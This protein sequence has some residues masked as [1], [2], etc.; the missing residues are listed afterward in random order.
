MRHPLTGSLVMALILAACGATAAPSSSPASQVAATGAASAAAKPAAA[1]SAPA[2]SAVAVASIAASSAAAASGASGPIKIGV[3]IPLTGSFA[4]LGN[5][6]K[7]GLEAYLNSIKRTAGGRQID[8]LYADDQ[9]KPDVTLT[10]S[11]EL[12]QNQ[13]AAALMGFNTTPSGY[14]VAQWVKDAHVPMMI[15]TNSTAEDFFRNPNFKSPYLTRWTQT[16]SQIVDVGAD[17]AAKQGFKKAAIFTSDFAPGVQAADLFASMFIRQGGAVAQEFYPPIGTTDFG[18][19]LAQLSPSADVLFTFLPGIDSLRFG[20]QFADYGGQHKPQIVDSFGLMTSGSN[21]LQLKDKAVGI[22]TVDIFDDSNEDP[23][24]QAFLKTWRAANGDKPLS[25]TL[26]NGY[27]SGQVLA[28]AIDK[29]QGK[30]ED[31]PAFLNALY[32]LSIDTAKGPVKLD[33]THDIVQNV[34]VFKTVKAGNGYSQQLL[35]TYKDTADTWARPDAE[36][37][38]FPFGKYKG[39]W[40]GMTKA[41]VDQALKP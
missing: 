11:K 38:S 40:V 8:V 10:K 41:Q 21:V 27:V 5:D 26:V 12:V 18:P 23:G 19:Y 4:P 20:Q 34:Y 35:S 14:A 6:S 24:T 1:A 29:V 15:T 30:A 28:T 22:V 16:H 32:G 39:K 2:A 7:D 17:W 3:V 37:A 13:G 33:Q 25:E 36:L 9:A 31:T